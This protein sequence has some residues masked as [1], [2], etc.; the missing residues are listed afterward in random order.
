MENE[1]IIVFDGVC[2]FCNSAVQFIVKRDT[3]NKFRFAALQ[4]KAVYD[5]LQRHN[6]KAGE[7][8]TIVLLKKGFVYLRS[9]AALQIAKELDMPWK[10]LVIFKIIPK[11]IRDFLYDVFAKHRYSWFGKRYDCL[12]HTQELRQRFLE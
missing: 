9:D 5:L 3:Q 12:I 6:L 1:L 7:L 10:I 11:F 4:N 8:D 2:N